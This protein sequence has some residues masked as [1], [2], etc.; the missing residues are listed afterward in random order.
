MASGGGYVFKLVPP[1]PGY[2]IEFDDLLPDTTAAT[3]EKMMDLG[4]SSM[5]TALDELAD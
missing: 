3:I 5:K 4:M 2:E 1:G